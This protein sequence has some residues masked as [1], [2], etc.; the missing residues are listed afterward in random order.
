[1][2]TLSKISLIPV[3]IGS[4]PYSDEK[5]A[6]GIVFENFKEAPFW[7]QLSNKN[8][9]EDMVSQY[10]ENIPGI[11]YEESEDRWYI[12]DEKEDFYEKLEEFFIDYENVI[13]GDEETL[14]KYAIS[15]NFAASLQLFLNKAKELQPPFLKGHITG[16]FTLATMLVD[17]SNKCAFY[18]ETM[19]EIILKGLILKALWQIKKFKEVSPN[20]IPIIFIDEP[21]VSQFGTTAFLTVSKDDITNLF[22]EISSVLKQKGALVGVHCCGKTDWSLILN[23]GVDIINFDGF[24]YAESLGFYAKEVEAFTKRGGLIAFGIVPT[25]DSEALD[26]SSPQT[27]KDKYEQALKYLTDKGLNKND[28]IKSSFVTPSCGAGSLSPEMAKKA[29]EYTSQ[30]SKILR[31]EYKI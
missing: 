23:S 11:F 2:E 24:D 29:M 21:S 17:R 4:L 8:R 27:L 16:P 6:L 9:N 15:E 13:S 1:M 19:R 28:I 22:K 14:E 30:L 3:A 25:L 18:D 20:S 10:T 7:P 5:E 31:E 26:K 12:S